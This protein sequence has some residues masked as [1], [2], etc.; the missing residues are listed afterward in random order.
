M[1]RGENGKTIRPKE[2][3]EVRCLVHGVVT[4]WGA[5]DAIQRLALE[6]GLDSAPELECLLSAGKRKA[7]GRS[8]SSQRKS[9]G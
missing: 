2:S 4:T 7:E 8:D 9:H 5:L 1:L 3:S 6:E